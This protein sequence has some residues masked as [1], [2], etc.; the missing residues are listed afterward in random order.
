VTYVAL[1]EGPGALYARSGDG[2]GSAE[3]L[4][5]HERQIL[6]GILSDDGDWVIARIGTH[7]SVAG[8]APG[9]DVIAMRRGEDTVPTHIIA[10]DFDEQ[11]IMLSPD[12]RWLAYQSD[13][14]G[15][16]EI[17]VRPFPDVVAGKW[18]VS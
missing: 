2:T 12:G 6:E 15:R 9:R 8:A 7:F 3:L 14:T 17:Y 4:L 13:E 11:A 10:T 1:H 18:T 16:N 5:A